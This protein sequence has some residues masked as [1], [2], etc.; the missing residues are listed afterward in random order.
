MLLRKQTALSQSFTVFLEFQPSKAGYEAG[1]MV[2]WSIY[3]YANIGV[4]LSV[5]DGALTTVYRTPLCEKEIPLACKLVP[6]DPKKPRSK[7]D[8]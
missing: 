4:T 2:W 6:N 3:S 7:A 5:V 1:I 8:Q